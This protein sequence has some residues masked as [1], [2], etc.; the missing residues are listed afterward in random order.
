[1]QALK[2]PFTSQQMTLLRMLYEESGRTDGLEAMVLDMFRSYARQQLG[3]EA[4]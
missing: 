4:K 2:I 1:M 3:R